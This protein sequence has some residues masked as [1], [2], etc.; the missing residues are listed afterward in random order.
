[1]NNRSTSS[2]R[3]AKTKRN[4]SS[5]A[6][7]SRTQGM[8]R[9]PAKMSHAQTQRGMQYENQGNYRQSAPQYA[10]GM[11]YDRSYGAERNEQYA[12]RSYRGQREQHEQFEQQGDYRGQ[13]GFSHQGQYPHEN[14]FG[15]DYSRQQSG[16]RTSAAR[17]YDDQMQSYRGQDQGRWDREEAHYNSGAMNQPMQAQY[18]NNDKDDRYFNPRASTRMTERGRSSGSGRSTRK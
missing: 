18:D 13:Y 9:K 6:K 16:R 17:Q 14:Q 1:M 15:G 7:G 10:P 12:P 2:N 3:S 4:T 11:G 5:S 8:A